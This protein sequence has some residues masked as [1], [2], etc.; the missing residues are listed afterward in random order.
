MNT[1]RA[2]CG[3]KSHVRF[4]GRA[5]ETHR[6]KDGR[7]LRSDPYAR[8]ALVDALATDAH[9]CLAVLDRR[10]L[11]GPVARAVELLAT[12]V[13][14]DL[15]TDADGRFVIARKVAKDRVISTVDPDARHGHK[16]ASRNFD[17]YKGHIAEDPDSEI[18]TKRIVTPGNVVDA[19]VAEELIADILPT[20]FDDGDGEQAGTGTDTSN[21]TGT[22]DD[23]VPV[24]YGDCAYGTVSSNRF[25]KT[26]VSSRS[27]GP[28][29]PSTGRTGSRKRSST[30]ISMLTRSLVRTR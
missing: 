5:G 27:A 13:G 24:A 7:A 30:S 19:A 17:G 20:T 1:W 14:Q 10:D 22:G 12:V 23:G 25:S 28:R 21:D 26:A 29:N 3:D 11:S 4:G 9:R 18:I 15:E 6:S 16:T 2:G 8:V